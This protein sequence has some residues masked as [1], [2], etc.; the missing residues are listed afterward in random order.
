MN[1]FTLYSGAISLVI[2][3]FLTRERAYIAAALTLFW[4]ARAVRNAQWKNEWRTL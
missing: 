3:A 1:R 4:M 2:T